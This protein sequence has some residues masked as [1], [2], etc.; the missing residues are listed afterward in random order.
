MNA[1]EPLND[2]QLYHH[3]KS[4]I[5]EL[6]SESVALKAKIDSLQ[7]IINK[8]R[9]SHLKAVGKN[10]RMIRAKTLCELR[11]S[12]GID[13]SLNRIAIDCSLSHQRIKSIS[14]LVKQ[15]ITG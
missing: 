14:S 1:T 5:D 10:A 11:H 7:K 9:D 4:E 2:L 12:G 13:W 3:L 6:N 15:L 8:Q